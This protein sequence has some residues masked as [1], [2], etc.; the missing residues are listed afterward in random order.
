[1]FPMLAGLVAG[2]T[3]VLAGPDHLTAIAPLAVRR[4]GRAWLSGVRWGLGHSAGVGMV[5]GLAM[6][7]RELIPVEW[8]SSWGER[9]VGVVLLGIGL[10]A[11]R[12]ALRGHIHAHEHEH[13]GVRHVHFHVHRHGHAHDEAGSHLHAHAAFGI[14]VLHGLA[15]SSHFLGVL[16]ALALPTTLAAA[17]YLIAFAVGTVAAMAAFSWGV[18]WLAAGSAR[19]GPALYRGLMGT[20]AVAAMGVGVFWLATSF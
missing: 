10:W 11:L 12:G 19:R 16:P 7:L 20:C 3:H 4:P 18:G 6:A 15:G 5:G 17:S 8:L 2:A 14:G 1:M 9:A 13:D